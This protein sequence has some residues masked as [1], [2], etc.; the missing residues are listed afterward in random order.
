MNVET[1]KYDPGID[2][3]FIG[4]TLVLSLAIFIIVISAILVANLLFYRVID[5]GRTVQYK[6]K[7]LIKNKEDCCWNSSP[8]R[9][10]SWEACPSK[11]EKFC[12]YLW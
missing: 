9:N 12:G 3:K 8:D 6:K 11:W 5:D 7:K 2:Y 10:S 1:I 4:A